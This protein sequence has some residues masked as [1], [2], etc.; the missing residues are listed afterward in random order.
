MLADY[1]RMHP[2]TATCPHKPISMCILCCPAFAKDE[3]RGP[4][5]AV[6]LDMEKTDFE[7]FWP[8][9]KKAETSDFEQ[10]TA[11]V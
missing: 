5:L 8:M 1:W 7:L 4:R 2:D 10:A 11:R 9:L 6:A 3:L